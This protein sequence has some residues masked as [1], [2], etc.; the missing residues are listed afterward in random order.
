[1]DELEKQEPAWKN[2]PSAARNRA[3]IK[4]GFIPHFF[5]IVSTLM[6]GKTRAASEQ[7]PLAAASELLEAASELFVA[8][9]ELLEAAS[10]LFVAASELL[11]AASELL[12]AA[13]WLLASARIRLAAAKDLLA[14][15]RAAKHQ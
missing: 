6:Y 9:S 4:V 10:E 15:L 3:L 11:E 12:A 7:R 13:K 2:H 1:M 14:V 5:E 8:A